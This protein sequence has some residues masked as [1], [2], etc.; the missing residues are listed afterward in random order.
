MGPLRIGIF[1]LV[2]VGHTIDGY[3]QATLDATLL[4]PVDSQITFYAAQPGYFAVIGIARDSSVHLLWHDRLFSYMSEDT[5]VHVPERDSGY[6]R[7]YFLASSNPLDLAALEQKPTA[8]S[9]DEAIAS[10]PIVEGYD[11][12]S[13]RQFFTLADPNKR[14]SLTLFQERVARTA[15]ARKALHPPPPAPRVDRGLSGSRYTYCLYANSS[16]QHI[17]WCEYVQ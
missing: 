15:D 12:G 16:Y 3:A 6:V 7:I 10:A 2:A 14:D 4:W 1:A 17:S 9:L 8:F 11:R 5:F 13:E